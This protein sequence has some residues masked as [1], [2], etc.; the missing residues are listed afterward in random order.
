MSEDRSAPE[1]HGSL[2]RTWTLVAMAILGAATVAA[3]VLA[4]GEANRQR[5]RAAAAQ[6]HSYDVMIVSRTLAGTIARAEAALGRYVISGDRRLG[7]LYSDAW[8][9]AT[10]Q[11]L[12]LSKLTGDNDVQRRTTRR[13]QGAVTE[14]GQELSVI[15]LSTSYRQNAQALARYYKAREAPSLEAIDAT[16]RKLIDEERAL[17]A[18][19]TSSAERAGARA[20]AIAQ[21]LSV[22]GVCIVLAAILLGVLTVHALS[23]RAA[24]QAAADAAELRADDLAEAVARATDELRT[25][26]EKLRQSQKMEAIGQLTGGIAHDFNNMLAVVSGG[27]ELA[28]RHIDDPDLAIRH[29]DSAAEGAARAAA[30]TRQLLTFSREGS[31]RPEPIEVGSLVRG[32]SDL[33]DRTLG[34]GITL[35]VLDMAGEWKIFGD[36]TQVENAILNLAVNAR[37]AMEG[38]GEMVVRA[39][40]RALRKEEVGHCAAGDYVALSVTDTGC[41]MAPDV[42]DRVFEPFFTTKPVGKGTGLGLS[43]VFG[44]VRRMGGEVQIET[45]PGRGT[46]ITLYLPRR[47]GAAPAVPVSAA[48]PEPTPQPAAAAGYRVLLVEDDPRVL[49]ASTSA[50]EELGH[51]VIACNDPLEA[52]GVLAEQGPVDLIVTDVLM[53]RQTGPEMIA[54]LLKR[55]PGLPVLYVTGFAGGETGATAGFGQHRVLRKPFTLAGLDRAVTAAVQDRLGRDDPPTQAAA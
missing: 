1:G 52:P 44:F 22:F 13:L 42:V 55:Q 21:V 38:R 33:L 45:A 18:S 43:Q 35:H 32:M 17:L 30:L 27:L 4:L 8:R 39:A 25:Q 46:T 51:E 36:R 40:A 15:A 37:D 53:P 11:L 19:R 31:I 12:R 5:D 54:G 49:S 24:A 7:Q 26:E 20:S 50:L 6:S 47:T 9:S 23:D 10:T 16:L 3:L 34:D 28:R 41:G 48:A 14:R 2:W 29:V